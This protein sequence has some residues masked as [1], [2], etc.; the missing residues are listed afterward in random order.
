M[1][2]QKTTKHSST[3]A[4][5]QTWQFLR[6]QSTFLPAENTKMSARFT[7]MG[8]QYTFLPAENTK[9]SAR[10]TETSKRYGFLSR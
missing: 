7:E 8:K 4:S 5:C 6:Q 9:M 10:F 1:Q 2:S 3:A